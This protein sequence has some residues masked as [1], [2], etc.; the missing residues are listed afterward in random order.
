MESADN[1]VYGVSENE[2][3]QEQKVDVNISRP[4]EVALL[5]IRKCF[6][7]RH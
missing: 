3:E 4:H 1:T 5:S 2:L 6:Y 7:F